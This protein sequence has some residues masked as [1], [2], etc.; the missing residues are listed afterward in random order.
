[1]ANTKF[2]ESGTAATQGFEFYT[3]TGTLSSGTITSSS[4]AVK[5]SVRSI[6]ASATATN[7]SAWAEIDGILADAGRRISFY[8]RF[9]GTLSS[10]NG[11]ADFCTIDPGIYGI[12]LTS[13]GKI[14]IFDA[15]NST[16]IFGTGTTVLVADTDYRITIQYTVTSTTVNSMTVY[17]NGVSEL[18]VTNKTIFQTGTANLILGIG[19]ENTSGANVQHYFAH[20]FVDDGTSGDPGDIRV[21]AKRPFANG[22]TNGMTGT[23]TPSGY[24]SGNARYVNERPL[25]V[26]NYVSVVA[27]GSAITEEYN[28]E[29]VSAGDVDITGKTIVDYTGWVYTKALIAETGKIIVNNVQTSISIT[30]ANKLFTQIAGSSTYPAGTGTDIGVVTA[31]TATTVSL[32][33]A[34]VVVAYLGTSTTTKTITGISRIQEIVNKTIAGLARIRET[35][36]QTITGKGRVQEIDTKTI[37]GISRITA[38]TLKTITGITRITAKTLQTITG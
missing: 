9:H 34:G 1:M 14:V 12:G 27:A 26:A 30:T 33:E 31:T 22:T 6:L 16:T 36:T 20:I 37:T 29:S 5:G 21:T 32:Y 2:I 17:I 7:G 11:A 8:F 10:Q 18:T 15:N 38:T 4:Q 28:I 25:N 24:G 23:G 35:T 3:S 19:Y 13:A